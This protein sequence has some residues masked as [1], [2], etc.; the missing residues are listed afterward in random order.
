MLPIGTFRYFFVHIICVYRSF[1]VPLHAKI[2]IKMRT[3][4]TKLTIVLL[5]LLFVLPVLYIAAMA[6]DMDPVWGRLIYVLTNIAIWSV[7]I[8]TLTRRK[9][10]WVML[11]M[12]PFLAFDAMHVTICRCMP[13]LLGWDTM[14]QSNTVLLWAALKQYWA[15]L[16]ALVVAVALY[17]LCILRS[18]DE[19]VLYYSSQRKAFGWSGAAWL[20]LSAVGVILAHTAGI[21]KPFIAAQQVAP[22][23]D[24]LQL[25]NLHAIK[26]VARYQQN[27]ALQTDYSV[28]TSAQSDELVILVLGESS[29]Y[30]HWQ[31]HGYRRETTPKLMLRQERL[32][33]FDSCY[34]PT[35]IDAIAV[36]MM[37]T[38]A[39]ALDAKRAYNAPGLSQL[40]SQAGFHTSWLSNQDGRNE[41]V[42][43]MAESCHEHY[44]QPDRLEDSFDE[45]LLSPLRSYIRHRSTAPQLA[46]VHT[47]GSRYSY[48]SRYPREKTIWAPDG[49]SIQIHRLR[50]GG[51]PLIL[52]GENAIVNSYDNTINYTDYILDEIIHSTEATGRPAVVVYISDHGDGVAKRQHSILYNGQTNDDG[53]VYHVPM[54]VWTS[55]AYEA[56]YPERV[57][58]LRSNVHKLVSSAHLYNTMLTLG[59]IAT[60]A[61]A[62]P[63]L[64]GT[65]VTADEA[66][67]HLDMNMN[68]RVIKK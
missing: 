47:M 61:E 64:A 34:T 27:K 68:S 31:L 29:R 10:M 41:F 18:K 62:M 23:G 28:H 46:V 65:A 44:I 35:N 7:L 11:C 58:A 60:D 16:I 22:L 50:R 4:K 45:V 24:I 26:Q 25:T 39:S 30:D 32:I 38:G 48:R 43:R 9:A 33:S 59:G 5:V 21:G 51:Y 14:L 6:G 2:G 55:P 8:A 42:K 20:I 57:S 56:R 40:F 3:P 52:D 19:R 37:M 67:Y 13:T 36:P 54:V 15:I 66:V 63:S 49:Y 53:Y 1:F 12:V 17:V